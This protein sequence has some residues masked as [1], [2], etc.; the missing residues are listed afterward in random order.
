MTFVPAPAI[1]G[2]R[3]HEVRVPRAQEL[4]VHEHVLQI[5]QASAS[6]KPGL[7]LPPLT[8]REIH[9]LANVVDIT[10][11]PEKKRHVKA[12]P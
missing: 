5:W 12:S 10:P 9:V 2:P 7:S 8:E 6:T 1:I 3:I 4:V 11:K